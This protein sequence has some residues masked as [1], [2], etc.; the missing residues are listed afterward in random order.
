MAIIN[1]C[2]LC[3][4]SNCVE[5]VFFTIDGVNYAGYKC[6]V[7]NSILCSYKIETEETIEDLKTNFE[8]FISSH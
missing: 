6:M 2:P 7:H 4:K 8:R 1:T 3:G 5:S